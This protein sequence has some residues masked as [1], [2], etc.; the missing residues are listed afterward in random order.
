[1]D[2]AKGSMMTVKMIGDSGHPC[3]V[4]LVILNESDRALNVYTWA[5]GRNAE[6]SVIMG[7]YMQKI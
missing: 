3:L 2:S 1:M 4:P 7:P 5:E 6:F